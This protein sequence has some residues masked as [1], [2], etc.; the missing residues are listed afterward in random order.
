[1][2]SFEPIYA[3]LFARLEAIAGLKTSSRRLRH[4]NDVPKEQQPALFMIQTGEAP[5]QVKGLPP[6][7][8]LGVEVYLYVS[9]SEDV[10]PATI[11]N[12]LLGAIRDALGPEPVSNT[13]TL[14]G[15]ASHAWIAGQIE[16]YDG[17]LGSQAVALV[18]IEILVA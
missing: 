7:W 13:Q 14:N 3:A 18:P 11:L 9:V 16:V 4:W 5:E 10:A 6:K 8:R 15:L 1:M 2:T 17:V 12:P